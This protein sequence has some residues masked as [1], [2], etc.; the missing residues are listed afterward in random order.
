MGDLVP[1]FDPQ[2]EVPADKI[3][4]ALVSPSRNYVTVV[5]NMH[6]ELGGDSGI[7]KYSFAA[8][9][10]KFEADFAGDI[11]LK[12]SNTV[13]LCLRGAQFIWRPSSKPPKLPFKLVFPDGVMLKVGEEII[14]TFQG[15]R[16]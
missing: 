15:Q 12:L 4:D 9:S 6:W 10:L 8:G 14:D 13:L 5:A 1:Y 16:V 2:L 3:P 7:T 11:R